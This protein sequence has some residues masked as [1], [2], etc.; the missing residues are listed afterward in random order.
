MPHGP[1]EGLWPWAHKCPGCG[2][3]DETPARH[4]VRLSIV[5]D[6]VEVFQV[7]VYLCDHHHQE[8]RAT[9][10]CEER[11]V[12]RAEVEAALGARW[13]RHAKPA[14]DAIVMAAGAEA[15]PKWAEA[16]VRWPGEVIGG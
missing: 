8:A 1:E 11:R 6:G 5:F 10:D 12:A 2:L 16:V 14:M 9:G 7:D 15:L 4:R 13:D 3:I